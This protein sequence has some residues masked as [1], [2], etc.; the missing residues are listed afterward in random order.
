MISSWRRRR[1]ERRA[2][3]KPDLELIV[4]NHFLCPIS[5][6]LMKDPVTLSTGATYDRESIE[7]WIEAGNTTCPITN[8]IL[9]NLEPVPNHA[10]RKL[11]QNWC[12]ENKSYGVER[13]PTPRTPVTSY[14]VTEILSRI[15]D[16]EQRQDYDKCKRL[17][18]KMKE[19]A[20]E[21]DRNRRCIVACGASR[22]LTATFDAF[23]R[24]GN[25][26]TEN[27]ALLE[28]I[29]SCMMLITPLL[30]DETS[31]INLSTSHSLRT[32]VWFMRFGNL[33]GRRNA[34]LVLRAILSSDQDRVDRVVEIE[35]ALEGLM[36]LIKEPICPTATKASLLAMYYLVTPSKSHL[37]SNKKAIAMR[38]TE[39]GLV[40]ML[41]E[42]IVDSEKSTCEKALGV[43]HGIC[44]YGDEEIREKVV[45]NALTIPVLVK[46]L[47]RVS[48]AATEFSVSILAKVV[49]GIADEE[50][51]GKAVVE[52]LELGAFQKV[53]LLLQ[54]GCDE[55]MREKVTELLKVMNVYRNKVECIDSS[56]FKHLKRPF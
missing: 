36:Q 49:L 39:M 5:L 16:A 10:I 28:E 52:A 13:V 23:S 41:L 12:V 14:Q 46:K 15:D 51:R 42:L 11:I 9:T 45:E 20:K 30:D 8:Q 4:P 18:C 32:V 56:D 25:F 22:V 35:G 53:L 47:L 6:E 1:A 55:I 27:V 17:V 31:R 48:D 40:P 26:V 44:S 19:T 29:L 38:L 2:A 21:S 37:E 43:L 34:V 3:K 7:R 50:K 54:I 24:K 33:S